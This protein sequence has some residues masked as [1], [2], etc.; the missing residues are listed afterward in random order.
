MRRGKTSC[1]DSLIGLAYGV[2]N[3]GADAKQIGGIEFHVIL[4]VI[5]VNLGADEDVRQA[6]PHLVTDPSANVFHEVIAAVKEGASAGGNAAGRRVGE[7]EAVAGNADS[8]K[9]IK[10]EL[11]GQFWLKQNVEVGEEGA[12]G[13]AIVRIVA[14]LVPPGGFRVEA[15]AVLEVDEVAADVE[16]STTLFGG[17]LEVHRIIIDGRGHE[18]AAAKHDVGLLGSGEVGEQKNRT[19][20]REQREFSQIHPLVSLCGLAEGPHQIDDA[21]GKN[22]EW[23]RNRIIPAIGSSS[24]R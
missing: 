16:V 11:L 5:V 10:A 19:N 14:A 6:V 7:R 13:L 3:R 24:S 8:G 2:A 22:R 9:D 21:P 12:N 20:E 15:E 23:C 17:R 4:D 18:N 1:C